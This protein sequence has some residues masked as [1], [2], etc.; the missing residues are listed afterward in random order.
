MLASVFKPKTKAVLFNN[1]LNPAAVVYP[2]EDLELLAGSAR[3]ST[4]SRSV[5]RSGSTWSS[6]AASISR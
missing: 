4:P 2:R 6:T 3:S 5:T 1:P